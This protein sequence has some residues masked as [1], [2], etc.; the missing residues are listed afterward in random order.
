MSSSSSKS[1]LRPSRP[2]HIPAIIW[3]RGGVSQGYWAWLGNGWITKEKKG[4]KLRSVGESLLQKLAR[5]SGEVAEIV[6]LAKIIQH[7]NG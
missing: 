4:P 3:E 1:T 2:L 6:I 7:V 5:E